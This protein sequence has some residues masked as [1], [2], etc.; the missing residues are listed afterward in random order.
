MKRQQ[1][2]AV[3]GQR[4]ISAF[5]RA[6]AKV[7]A[8][9]P[10][11]PNPQ[12]AES[13]TV[14]QPPSKKQRLEEGG[15]VAIDCTPEKVEARQRPAPP[16]IPKRTAS[17][18]SKAYRK[19]VQSVEQQEAAVSKASTSTAKPKYTPLEQQV[20]DLKRK[21]P[22]ALL[23]VEVCCYRTAPCARHSTPRT[24]VYSQHSQ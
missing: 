21:H 9:N 14:K 1:A 2:P 8:S 7:D 12:K 22:D 24:S 16:P 3:K 10:V 17:N 18:K 13:G 20:V 15:V 23:V 4:S 6:Q 5:F 19:L 11:Q